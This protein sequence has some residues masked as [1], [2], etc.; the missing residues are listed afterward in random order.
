MPA[1][2]NLAGLRRPGHNA[3]S[4]LERPISSH[5]P[6]AGVAQKPVLQGVLRAVW[7]E[8]DRASRLQI[9]QDSPIAEASFKCPIIDTQNSNRWL[10]HH[11]A[12]SDKTK[13]GVW[14]NL[15]LQLSCYPGNGFRAH[16]KGH[17][18]EQFVKPVRSSGIELDGVRQPFCKGSM[19][20]FWVFAEVPL[21]NKEQPH[22]L[23]RTWPSLG[24]SLIAAVATIRS[25]MA[26]GADRPGR[27]AARLHDH[28]SRIVA[29]DSVYL[30]VLERV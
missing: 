8:I 25:N 23:I 14:T 13:N 6:D 27:L 29:I 3:C 18:L 16:F 21:N 17:E 11:W 2:H 12:G 15:D 10:P 5:N 4:V 28:R 19:L 24:L 30:E 1:I 9:N 22:V 26:V 20:A 7:Q